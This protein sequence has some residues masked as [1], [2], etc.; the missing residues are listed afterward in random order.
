MAPSESLIAVNPEMKRLTFFYPVRTI[1]GAQLAFA[2]I[3]RDFAQR[4]GWRVVLVD[5]ENGFIRRMLTEWAVDFE[6][7]PYQVGGPRV[8]VGDTTLFL[9]Y[10]G[11]P[12]DLRALRASPAS[13]VILWSLF[14]QAIL[15]YFRFGFVY[16]RLP[17]AVRAELCR[18]VEPRRWRQIR[19]FTGDL[20]RS[21]AL[22]YMDGPNATFPASIGL[23]AL[24]TKYLPVPIVDQPVSAPQWSDR[25]SLAWLGRLAHDKANTVC[26][27]LELCSAY[28]TAEGEEI[29]FHIIG[30]GPATAR[31]REFE[32]PGMRKFFPGVLQGRALDEYVAQHVKVGYAMGT[33][34]LEFAMRGV[35]TLVGDYSNGNLRGA[36]LPLRWLV[37]NA[38]FSLGE[39]IGE[40]NRLPTATVAEAIGICRDEPAA[41]E[42]GRH[43]RQYAIDNHLIARVCNRLEA[44]LPETR[45]TFEVMRAVADHG[46]VAW[47]PRLARG[48]ARCK[49]FF[50]LGAPFRKP[51]PKSN[52]HECSILR[53]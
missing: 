34:L 15:A 3:A 35:P 45:F 47:G 13:R 21:G 23:P 6:Y 26:A 10:G 30:D 51:C 52:P 19:A 36:K 16:K 25:L 48:A 49:T 24:V 1:G 7:L 38:D 8:D 20:E 2:R 28:A 31:L 11:V 17:I 44:Y 37:P 50:S 39:I 40:R 22:L 27:M 5:F 43:C 46:E 14:P 42:L 29:D 9:S 4:P 18:L 41:R 12:H 32:A 33:S 53:S